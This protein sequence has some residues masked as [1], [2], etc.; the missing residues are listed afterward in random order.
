MLNQIT[1]FLE[2]KPG[3]LEEVTRTLADENINLH[4]LSIADTTD[5]GILR[6]IASDPDKAVRVLKEKGFMVKT[7]S[8]I[9]LAMGH[10]PGSLHKVLRELQTLDISIEYMYAFTSRHSDYDAIVILSLSDQDAAV[11]KLNGA[12][13]SILGGELLDQLCK[14]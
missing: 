4:A 5:F 2:N 6:M 3:R 10:S 7:A 11:S 9:A 1:V 14:S 13:F 12:G 8:V